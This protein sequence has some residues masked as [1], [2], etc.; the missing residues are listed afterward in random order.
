MT[1]TIYYT[2]SSLDGFIAGPGNDL[3]WLVSGGLETGP[4]DSP[5]G[6]TTFEAS[7]GAVV[8]GANTYEWVLAHHP[9]MTLESWYSQP[10][11]V[12][13]HRTLEPI[14][15]APMHFF[16]GDVAVLHPQLVKAAGDRDV[17]VVGGGDLAGQF[18]DAGLLDEVVVSYAPVTLG[19][20]APLLPRRAHWRLVETGRLGDFAAVRWAVNRA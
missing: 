17:W 5:F 10:S 8:M 16:A 11:W 3:E 7:V 9:Q 13:T 20:G 14:A 4:D 1:R 19:S 2:A 18:L 15:G 12:V 6:Y